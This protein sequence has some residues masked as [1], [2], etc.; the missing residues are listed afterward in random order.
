M[1]VHARCFKHTQPNSWWSSLQK[2]SHDEYIVVVEPSTV[3]NSSSKNKPQN[4]APKICNF[5]HVLMAEWEWNPGARKK[6]KKRNLVGLH[7]RLQAASPCVTLTVYSDI[8]PL[9]LCHSGSSRDK[10]GD[11]AVELIIFV[12]LHHLH[13]EI[14]TNWIQPTGLS[15]YTGHDFHWKAKTFGKA[16]DKGRKGRGMKKPKAQSTLSTK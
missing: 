8:N 4:L 13:V 15:R 9:G 12:R 14:T 1:N 7:C 10:V 6:K 11:L 3:N 2:W 5:T 16:Q